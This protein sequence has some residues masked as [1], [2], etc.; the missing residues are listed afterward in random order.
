M[1]KNVT[2]SETGVTSTFLYVDVETIKR[3]LQQKSTRIAMSNKI[4]GVA[5]T[6]IIFK[7]EF[8]TILHDLMEDFYRDLSM[9]LAPYITGDEI[10]DDDV[11]WNDGE[12]Y[13]W[14]LNNDLP[15]RPNSQ[16]IAALNLDIAVDAWLLSEW[17]SDKPINSEYYMVD[18]SKKSSTLKTGL[19][20]AVKF[21][22]K[23][24]PML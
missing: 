9:I 7:E 22:E 12:V 10:M 4:E 24:P 2:D 1:L 5:N 15:W 6:E 3:R 17:L 16:K 23:L 11:A 20:N 21:F 19:H 13:C 14:E 18:S 8:N